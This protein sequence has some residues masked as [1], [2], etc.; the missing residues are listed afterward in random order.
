MLDRK[1]GQYELYQSESEEVYQD[2]R[3]VALS[4]GAQAKRR[5]LAEYE[6]ES[7]ADLPDQLTKPSISNSA[8]MVDAH[9]GGSGLRLVVGLNTRG[10]G[11]FRTI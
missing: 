6:P 11:L 8:K 2:R 10:P 3:Q 1:L 9:N 4:T 5:A 7:T